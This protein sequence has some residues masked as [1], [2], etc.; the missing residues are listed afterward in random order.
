MPT[1][2]IAEDEM[3]IRRV[4]ALYFERAGYDVLQ[5]ENGEEALRCWKEHAVDGFVLDL[6]KGQRRE[7]GSDYYA[8]GTRGCAESHSRI[9][10]RSGRLHCEAV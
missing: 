1:I 5:A 10:K 6:Q 8:D 2:V 7:H 4:L 9:K 3:P